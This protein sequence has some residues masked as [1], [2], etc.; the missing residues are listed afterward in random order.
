[1]GSGES[2]DIKIPADLPDLLANV[3]IEDSVITF[4]FNLPV[5]LNDTL[6]VERISYNFYDIIFFFFIG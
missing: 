2:N 5:I 3:S 1:M 4:K 6:E